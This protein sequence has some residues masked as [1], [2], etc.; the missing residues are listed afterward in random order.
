[1]TLKIA[2]TS[3]K[4]AYTRAES[5]LPWNILEKLVFNARVDPNWLEHSNKFWYLKKTKN[6]KEFFLVD[7]ENNTRERAFDHE[8]LIQALSEASGKKYSLDK[9]PFDTI[10]FANNEQAIQF[11]I[12]KKYWIY[13]INTNKCNKVQKEEKEK[14]PNELIS[15]DGNWAAFIR[16]HNIYVRSTSTGE[17]I[18]L[19]E[20]GVQYYD[21]GVMPDSS[22]YAIT[23]RRL[24]LS[25][26]P[27]ALWSP[28]SKKLLVHKV[29]QRKV[30]ELYLIQS[31]ALSKNNRPILHRYRY[32][33]PGDEDV[34]VADLVILDIEKRTKVVAKYKPQVIHIISPIEIKIVWWAKDSKRVFFFYPER[35]FKLGTFHE[36]NIGTG[37]T[38][39]ILEEHETTHIDVNQSLLNPPN[40]RILDESNELIMFSQRDGWGHLYLFDIKNGK[41]KNQITSGQWVVQEI[42]HIDEISRLIYFYGGGRENGRDSYYRHLYRIGFD[43]KNL[44]LLTPEDADHEVIF[45]PSGNYFIDNFSQV[46]TILA[47]N[48]R[49]AEGKLI[50]K[51]EEADLSELFQSGWR[52]PEKFKVKAQDGKTDLY[53]MLFFPTNF[54]PKKKYPVIDSIYPGPQVIRTPKHFPNKV[55][56][57]LIDF[58]EPQAIAELGFI[59]LTIDGQG[60]PFRSKAF[61]DVAYGN[62]GETISDHPIGIKQL[63]NDHPY[64][65]LDQVGIYGH[66]GGGFA[67]TRAILVFPDFY[68]VAVSSAGNHD[69]RGYISTWGEKY[70]GMPEGDNYDNVVNAKLAKN[71]KGNLLLAHGD[72]DDNV[73][74]SLT[75]Q[76]V[77][78]LIKANKDFDMLILPNKNHLFALDAYFIRKKWDYFVLHLLGKEPPKEYEIKGPDMDFLMKLF[79]AQL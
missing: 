69:Q 30:K 46:D 15:P 42:V 39:K 17:E 77:D 50:L 9:I 32:P 10:K 28:D 37:E 7:P 6:K 48:L 22:T 2:N 12:R 52:W 19:T 68:K 79:S 74:H 66:S 76:M 44:Q 25:L 67:S 60:T 14:V 33:F 54:D 51:L 34:A 27:V 62:L 43:G 20:D 13:E 71:L 4:D 57:N 45:F 38:R 35:D 61:H 18:Q 65:D 70:Q 56:N 36:V 26:P 73:H 1:M 40:I 3:M 41:L 11:N 58:W 5:F 75:L 59:V 53:G 31:V 49:N 72:M 55:D 29:D 78:A 24:G 21:Y 8:K 64:M 47:S 16:K 23:I 63:V